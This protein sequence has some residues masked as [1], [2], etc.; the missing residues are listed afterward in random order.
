MGL[1][2]K[3]HF[4]TPMGESVSLG[5]HES[6]SRMWENQVGRSRPFWKYFFPQAQRIF[7]DS[8]G[9][10]KLEEFYGAVNYVTPSYI[11]VEA[12]EATY[13][14]H[15]LLRFELERALLTGDLRVADVA[16]EW[17]KRFREYFGIEVDKDANGCLQDVHWSLGLMGY[18]PTYTLGNLHSAQFFV[19]AQKDIPDLSTQFEKGDFSGLLG[20][21]RSNIHCHGMCYRAD[22]LAEKVTG[23]PLSHKPLVDYM[24]KKYGEIYGF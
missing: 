6:Q 4:G 2:K 18:F 21:L 20:W 13:N 9:D 12:D 5:I 8:L 17:N 15:I 3:E 23:K 10:V 11:R 19:Q 1:N 16:S 24:N 22:A 7:R 14:L